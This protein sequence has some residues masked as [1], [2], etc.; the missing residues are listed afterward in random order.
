MKTEEEHQE[1][2]TKARKKGLNESLISFSME[3]PK[4]KENFY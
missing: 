1:N 4:S 3:T 2:T